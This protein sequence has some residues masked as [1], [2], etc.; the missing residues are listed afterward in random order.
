MLLWPVYDLELF[1]KQLSFDMIA[2]EHFDKFY[3]E[4]ELSCVWK[5]YTIKNIDLL[6]WI[7]R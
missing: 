2:T 4:V 5:E 3:S 7:T 1:L 6:E